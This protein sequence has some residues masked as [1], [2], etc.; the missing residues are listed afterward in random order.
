[1]SPRCILSCCRTSFF[2]LNN[3][4]FNVYYIYF[5][6]WSISGHLACFPVFDILNN[7]AINICVQI[8][9]QDFAF[10]SLE[11]I[12]RSRIAGSYSDSIFNFM[13]NCHTI[14]YS[15]Y[16]ILHSHQWYR[17]VPISP[18]PHQYLLFSVHFPN[19]LRG[20]ASFLVLIS[21]LYILF[22][23]M[24]IQVL[25]LFLHKVFLCC[26]VSEVLY[27]VDNNSLSDM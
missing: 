12:P 11:Y 4:P 22:R 10:N 13:R 9:L 20:W 5:I 6:N 27:I 24:F 25:C 14:F 3:I 21:H 23:E 15:V 19:H 17:K 2:R 7:S 26:W 1:M 8:S 18:H 16:I